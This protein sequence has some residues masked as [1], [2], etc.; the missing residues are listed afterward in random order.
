MY[1]VKTPPSIVFKVPLVHEEDENNLVLRFPDLVCS[2]VSSPGVLCWIVYVW[3]SAAKCTLPR[4]NSPIQLPPGQGALTDIPPV[5]LMTFPQLEWLFSTSCSLIPPPPAPLGFWSPHM[6]NTDEFSG[7]ARGISGDR[8][9]D[10]F[11]S[12]LSVREERWLSSLRSRLALSDETE[13]D[14]ISFILL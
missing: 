12:D 10:A 3:H 14:Q 2:L 1:F 7:I 8:G 4:Y 5:R 6:G 9:H 13:Y 11:S